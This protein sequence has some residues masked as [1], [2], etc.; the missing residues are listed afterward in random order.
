MDVLPE[1]RLA[2]WSPDLRHSLQGGE[3]HLRGTYLS[4][5]NLL[6]LTPEHTALPS[7]SHSTIRCVPLRRAVSQ[8]LT[9][10]L[11]GND[12]SQATTT[13]MDRYFGMGTSVRDML[14][15]YDCPDE[16][17]YLPATTFA[18]THTLTRSRAIC[19][20]RRDGALGMRSRITS[21]E[22]AWKLEKLSEIN[23]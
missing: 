17:I 18:L 20:G 10:L 12:P 14:P 23:C 22:T 6:M 21:L 2:D 5:H 8:G 4:Q 11:A 16:S 3:N 1:L 19:E 9:Y 15:G 7:R 13:W